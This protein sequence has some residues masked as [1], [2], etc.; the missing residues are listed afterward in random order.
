MSQAEQFVFLF[1]V[2]LGAE[3]VWLSSRNRSLLHL[4]AASIYACVSIIVIV[5]QRRGWCSQSLS[6]F[7]RLL[8]ALSASFILLV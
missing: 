6:S 1:V 5:L 2:L 7:L 3:H 8:L 4:I